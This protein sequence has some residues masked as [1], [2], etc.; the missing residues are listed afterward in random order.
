MTDPGPK[1]ATRKREVALVAGVFI[2]GAAVMTLEIV[3]TRVIAPIFGV[4]LF[5]WCALLAVTL[6]SLAIGYSA[7]G[8]LA[9]RYPEIRTF[10]AMVA[11]AGLALGAAHLYE[12]AVLGATMDLGPRL[13]PVVAALAVFAPALCLLGT[14]GPIAVRLW[15]RE[16]SATGRGA[17]LIYSVSTLGSLAGTVVV[18]FFLV[19]ALDTGSILLVTAATLALVGGVVALNS[20]GRAFGGTVLFVGFVGLAKP[21]PSL[22]SGIR[23]LER[24]QSLYG[25]VEV[26]DDS[27]R[28]V[29]LLRADHSIIG[30]EWTADGSAAFTFL[31]VIE[32]VR[33]ARP[34]AKHVLEIGLGTGALASALE[35]AGLDVDVVELDPAVV[36]FAT[37]HFGFVPRRPVEV[38]DARTFLNRTQKRYDAI[39]HDTFTGG[40]T[41]EHLL[42]R[43]VIE[44]IHGLLT[45]RGILVLNF[46]GYRAGPD[47]EGSFAVTRTLRSE[48][49]T[50]RAF[51]DEPLAEG[52]DQAGNIAFFAADAAIDFPIPEGTHF[53]NT[54]CERTLRSF[55]SWEILQHVPE[56]D[57]VTDA[58]NPLG[59]LELPAARAHFAAMRELLP[60]DVWL[61]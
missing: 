53:E 22:P 18:G 19:P 23:I 36:R 57:I 61:D 29:R 16:V 34:E 20:V 9:D 45:P 28:R 56:G 26:I 3:G 12:R 60:A 47:A 33:F 48:F 15:V 30:A 11:F 4:G 54:T 2:C 5:V 51:W 39:I 38:E 46:P 24:A 8:R 1:S 31:H 59:V 49:R 25:L 37:K 52:P 27:N 58:H 17:G 43:E 10:G 40:T 6:A 21:D 7:G 42:S 14:T 55:P 50:V 44:R 13:G 32:A 41:P 35:T